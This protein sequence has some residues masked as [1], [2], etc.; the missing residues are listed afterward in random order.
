MS[1]S[2]SKVAAFIFLSILILLFNPFVVIDGQTK[3]IILVGIV[4]G[5]ILCSAVV[6]YDTLKPDGLLLLFFALYA[7]MAARMNK[8]EYDFDFEYSKAIIQPF[9][10]LFLFATS[11]FIARR[12]GIRFYTNALTIVLG[13]VCL[14]LL[15]NYNFLIDPPAYSPVGDF[16][17]D[18]YQQVGTVFGIVGI[19]CFARFL[20]S[21]WWNPITYTHLFLFGVCAWAILIT[22]ARGEMIAFVVVIAIVKFPRLFIGMATAAALSLPAI[23]AVLARYN[24]PSVE[25]FQIALDMGKDEPRVVLLRQSLELILDSDSATWLFG[26]GA[27]YF[28]KFYELPEAMHPHNFVLEA[29]ISGGILLAVAVILLFVMPVLKGYVRLL[30][31]Q[32][33]N[34]EALA[35]SMFVLILALKST[36]FTSN[37]LLALALPFFVYLR[38]STEKSVRQKTDQAPREPM[39][40]ATN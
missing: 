32:T 23:I 3:F 26:G 8:L 33:I 25:R 18:S 16:T 27:D 10:C 2:F 37:W 5:S 4:C 34:R 29:L 6:P 20:E 17:F 7:T 21:P 11:L 40:L 15:F 24:L 38:Q 12:V 22:P 1:A 9:L 14:A 28:Q 39:H 13:L 19:V 30:L 31:R 35:I 36:A